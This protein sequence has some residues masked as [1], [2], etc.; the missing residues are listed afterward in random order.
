[1]QSSA[2]Q[3]RA[4]P[5]SSFTSFSLLPA[6]LRL[7]TWQHALD[8]ATAG[9]MIR[10]TVYHQVQATPHSCLTL[11]GR[12]CGNHGHCP[13]YTEGDPCHHSDCMTDGYFAASDAFPEPE[14]P[15]SGMQLQSLSLANRESRGVV[16][17]S[18]YGR[19]VPVYR[20]RWHPGI[21]SKLVRVDP[22]GDTLLVVHVPDMSSGHEPTSP[23]NEDL[24]QRPTPAILKAFPRD[25]ALF[26][27]FRKVVSSFQHVAY[28]YEG[29]NR[30]SR[31]SEFSTMPDFQMLLFYFESL[32][33]LCAWPDPK[34]WR[35]AVLDN[36]VVVDDVESLDPPDEHVRYLVEEAA[37]IIGD[38]N[39]YAQAQRDHCPRSDTHWIPMPRDL[40]RIGC[41]A[42]HAWLGQGAG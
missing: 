10:A 16:T 31:Q 25:K 21:Q 11:C 33:R 24:T 37:D 15:T 20:G 41:Y 13:R 14:D 8:N 12:F 27:Q 1:M 6:E 5:G 40:E 18:A 34:T 3:G 23:P 19:Q 38:Q 36:V 35:D 4:V 17:S 9:R 42:Q 22:A 7:Q 30:A 26:R 32:K 29:L 2:E 39:E 28:R